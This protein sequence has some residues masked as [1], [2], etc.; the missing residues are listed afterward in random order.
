MGQI[1]THTH[2]GA[3][4]ILCEHPSGKEQ[5]RLRAEKMQPRARCS[6]T[7]GAGSG[8]SKVAV[9]FAAIPVVNVTTD[10]RVGSSWYRL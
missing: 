1:H 2:K 8:P 5:D 6:G 10:S 3:W 4:A 9:V 7:L